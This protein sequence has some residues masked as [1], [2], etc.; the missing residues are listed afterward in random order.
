MR[1]VMRQIL[2]PALL[3]WS[4]CVA[5]AATVASAQDKPVPGK[6][7]APGAEQKSKSEDVLKIETNLV[8]LKVTVTDR[9]GKA[10]TGLRKEDFSIYEDGV[11]QSIDFFSD[12]EAPVSWGL[13]LDRSESMSGMIRDVYRAALHVIDDG[14]E[15][16]QMFVVAFN[17]KVETLS[18][19]TSDRHRLENSVLGLRAGGNTA[20]YDAVDFALDKMRGG[21]HKKKVLVL[22]TDG[23]DNSSRLKFR[24][25]IGR[26]EEEGVLVYAV[27]MFDGMGMW[28]M[29]G[30]GGGRDEI[31][32]LAE[33]TGAFAHF[34]SDVE[35]CRDAMQKIAS[36]VSRQYNLGYY[37]VNQ[38]RDGKWRKIR[39][40]AAPGSVGTAGGLKTEYVARTRTGYYAPKGENVK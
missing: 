31:A 15:L 29:K 18:D 34:P 23:E 30:G 37:P 21:K 7:P 17:E 5:A 6:S 40:V 12:E 22:V 8:P 4:I 28:R 14:T 38:T 35:E 27:G 16:D 33:V 36:E 32:K 10:V 11:K 26:A 19:F 20:W 13:V 2:F 9:L 39:V 1:G 25:L 24:R 3:V